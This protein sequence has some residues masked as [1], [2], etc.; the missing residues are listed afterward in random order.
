LEKH[1]YEAPTIPKQQ[2]NK[3]ESAVERQG[4]KEKDLKKL[5]AF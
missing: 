5:I 2:G 1:G 3:I 4:A